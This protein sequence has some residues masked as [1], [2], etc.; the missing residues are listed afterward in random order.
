V[1]EELNGEIQKLQG[2]EAEL[3]AELAKSDLE[4]HE[5]QVEFKKKLQE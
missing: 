2:R 3:L 1:T 4:K 5:M